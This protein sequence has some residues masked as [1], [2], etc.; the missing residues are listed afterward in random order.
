MNKKRGILGTIFNFVW[1]CVVVA[2]LIAFLKVNNITTL[3]RFWDVIVIKTQEITSCLEKSLE[4]SS[5]QCNLNL[6]IND[7]SSQK[8]SQSVLNIPTNKSM[9]DLNSIRVFEKYEEVKYNRKEWNHW[10]AYD[11]DC[12]SIREEV[13]YRSAKSV[14][15]LDK[16]KNPTKDYSK[17]CYI[18]KGVWVD[19][20]TEETI[21]DPKNIDIDHH[22]PLAVV[23]SSGG[24]VW[25]TNKKE[26][27]AND[28]DILIAISA[29][30]NRTKGKKTPSEW[31]PDNKK[32][33]CLYAKK[34]IDGLKKYNLYITQEDKNVLEKALETCE[35][36]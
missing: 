21:T 12:W 20:Y 34:Y 26:E 19:P 7:Y 17:A 15:L 13:L 11:R 30:Q 25:K 23:A 9:Q 14:E 35:V 27:Y 3:S 10:I 1:V 24:Q 8:Q 2:G 16:D 5:F 29:E 22:I 33:H 32:S 18:E 36:N 6:K 31:M 28:F 4:S